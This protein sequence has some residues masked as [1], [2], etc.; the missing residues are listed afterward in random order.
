MHKKES[1]QPYFFWI[2]LEMTGLDPVCD[3][4]LEAA[5]IITTPQLESVIEYAT[6]VFQSPAVLAEMNEWCQQHHRSSGLLK[7]ISQG[8]SETK[9]DCK[10][11]EF[12][13]H[14]YPSVPAILFGNSVHQDRKFIDRYLPLFSQRL[15]Y[16]LMD[17]SSFKVIF[18][19]ILDTYTKKQ[20]CHRALDDIRESI[21]ELQFYLR[22]LKGKSKLFNAISK[23]IG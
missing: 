9:L 8:V 13:D 23:P 12:L 4:I 15:H 3:R 2:D 5:V 21:E 10:L 22:H 6:T 7:H 16:R 20:N 1:K 18:N 19:E 14:Y 11:C 17:V